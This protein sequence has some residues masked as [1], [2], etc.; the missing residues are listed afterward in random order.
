MDWFKTIK[1][2]YDLGCYNS[3]SESP[4]YVGKFVEFG[5]ITAEQYK[6]ITGSVYPV[7]KK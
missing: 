7:A 6:Q 3:D 4:M 2:Y 5:K 1:R